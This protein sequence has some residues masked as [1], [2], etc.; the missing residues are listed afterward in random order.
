MITTFVT[1]LLLGF[2][3]VFDLFERRIPDW[4]TYSATAFGL[5]FWLLVGYYPVILYVVCTFVIS[6]LLYRIGLWAG[7][8]VKL[9]TAFAALNPHL[10]S[11]FGF[12]I[13]APLLLFLLSIFAAF[14]LSFPVMLAVILFRRDL[15]AKLFSNFRLILIKAFSISVLVNAFGIA[16]IIFTFLPF[17]AELFAALATLLWRPSARF[18][19]AFGMIVLISIFLRV[20]SMRSYVFRQEKTVDELKEGDVPADFIT[21][22]GVIIPFSWK[23]AVLAEMGMI[24]VRINPLRAAGLYSE[25]IEWLR[26]KGIRRI[27]VRTAMPYVPFVLVAYLF[28]LALIFFGG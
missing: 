9:F 23:T 7:G 22:D 8:D 19:S 15:R 13:P 27:S 17:P 12:E 6:Y 4:L 14:I 20:L 11:V 25:D 1:L 21:E 10:I 16:G 28:I 26:S 3:T 5:V 18:L 24:S 2:A